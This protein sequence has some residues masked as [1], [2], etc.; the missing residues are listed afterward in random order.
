MPVTTTSV[1][2]EVPVTQTANSQNNVETHRKAAGHHQEAARHLLEAVTHS[3][4]GNEAE[5]NASALKA[6]AHHFNAGEYQREDAKHHAAH[7]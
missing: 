6:L 5:A 4:G 7:G 2:N 3:E 1:S